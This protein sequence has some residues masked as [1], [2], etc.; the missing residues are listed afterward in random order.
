MSVS[1][2]RHSRAVAAFEKIPILAGAFAAV[3]GVVV[4]IGWWRDIEALRTIV[5]GLIPTI[6]NTA[7]AFIIGGVALLCAIPSERDERFRKATSVFGGVLA[8]LGTLFF[9]ERVTGI[10]LGIDLLLFGDA[11]RAMDWIPPGRPAINS[12]V[13]M[14][15]DGLALVFIDKRNYRG[16]RPSETLSAVGAMI[17]FT[18]IVGYMYGVRG[19]YS[20]GPL[21]GMALLTA[22]TLCT[23]SVGILFT[24]PDRGAV[25]LIAGADASGVMARRL[26][27]AAIIV[28]IGLGAIWLLVNET[29]AVP[30]EMAVSA[31]VGAVVITFILLVM[32]AAAVVRSA[33]A[34]REDLLVHAEQA[35]AAAERAAD[36]TGR[37]RRTAEALS[38]ALTPIEVARVIVAEGLPALGASASEVALLAGD[39]VVLDLMAVSGVPA[40]VADA[41]RR[42]PVASRVPLAEAVRTMQPVLLASP[43]EIEQRYPDLAPVLERV[44]IRAM[45]VTPMVVDGRPLGSLSFSFKAPRTFDDNDVTFTRTLG[46]QCAQALERA[47]LFA[48]EQSARAEAE[49]ANRAKTEFLAM[50]SH[51][52]RTPL[53]AI[54]GYTELMELGISGPVSDLQREQLGRIRRSQRHLLGIIEDLL[55]LSRLE[56][57]APADI[58]FGQVPIHETLGGLET[59]IA[60]QLRARNITYIYNKPDV[61]LVAY[62]NRARVEQIVLN[63]LSNAIKYTAPGGRVGLSSD[64]R[65]GRV[66]IRVSDTGHGIPREKLESIFEPFTRVEMD[67]TRTT[68]GT[69][70][71]LAISRHLARAMFG[72]L[73]ARSEV[74]HGSI[75]TLTLPMGPPATPK[76]TVPPGA[77]IVAVPADA[78]P[79]HRVRL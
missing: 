7:V 65:N 75:F 56:H 45:I 22:V 71:G 67:L 73:T 12:T 68:E 26:L 55:D 60:P 51:E 57:G 76:A 79:L 15:L 9:F 72:D 66:E 44:N 11:V 16:R 59:L 2:H 27:P 54:A 24:R 52:L 34:E 78:V 64:L 31:F 47:R 63:L 36:R 5:P 38:S 13:V 62:A 4:L 1:P 39:G 70:L 61:D 25:A 48:A 46:Q 40:D 6:P 10:D 28:P 18:A 50:M 23:L 42:F 43:D 77:G 14:T 49:A 37:L 29:N 19:L 41:W 21:T 35:R 53:N 74:G 8:T 20:F 3:V 58:E 32:R 17:S 30:S 69:G 33:D